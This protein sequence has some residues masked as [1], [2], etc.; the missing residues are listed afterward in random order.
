[1]AWA[2]LLAAAPRWI[3]VAGLLGFMGVVVVR[4]LASHAPQL[5]WVRPRMHAALSVAL[6]A[7]VVTVQLVA[8]SLT[9]ILQMALYRFATDG[10]VPGFDTDELRGAFRPR[11]SLASANAVRSRRRRLPFRE[12]PPT[13]YH[14][15]KGVVLSRTWLITGSSRG[16]GRALAGQSEVDH[17]HGAG[18]AAG[19]VN[20]IAQDLFDPG[21]RQQRNI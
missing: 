4:R 12:R 1:M 19:A 8:A 21:I 16:L 14:Y 5:S 3:E 7:W 10:S 13:P 6:V 18:L 2:D 15:W 9:G 11:R 20:G 17:Q